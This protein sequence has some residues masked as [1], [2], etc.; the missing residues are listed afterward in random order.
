VYEPAPPGYGP[1]HEPPPPPVARHVAPNVSLW[2]G[3][4]VGWFVPFGYL[5]C[6]N[7]ANPYGPVRRVPWNDYAGHGIML[8]GDVGARLGRN[9]TVFAFWERAEL[10]SGDGFE[11][12]FGGQT[13]GDSDF[14]GI[15]M[16]ASSDADRLGFLTEIALGYRQFR[17]T[18]EDGTER[19]FTDGWLEG[20]I[21]FGAD[22]RL[23]PMFSVQ[24][25]LTLGVGAFGDVEHVFP[26]D[27][28]A[29]LLRPG[30]TSDSHSWFTLG[31]GG[32]VDLFGRK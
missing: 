17:A 1:I 28:S 31:V 25:L 29:N 30:D 5:Y 7:C 11:D 2:L 15:G 22:I 26:D 8:E 4:R 6:E 10:W 13:G 12:R 32:H 23:N 14:W 27:S 19:Q 3:A 24:P 21:G 9:Y 18:F 20:R 16:Q